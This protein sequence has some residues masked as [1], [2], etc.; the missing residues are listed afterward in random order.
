MIAI[1]LLAKARNERQIRQVERVLNGLFE[2]LEARYEILGTTE[3]KW[4]K[5][6]ITGE[7]ET[8]A[9]KYVIKN[10][11]I[12]PVSITKARKLTGLKGFIETQ[13]C[14]S[15]EM[16]VDIGIFQP[17]V[18]FG[19]IS[20]RSLQIQLVNGMEVELSAVSE[21]FALG[22]NMSVSYKILGIN[23]QDGLIE[24]ELSAAQL[25]RI[26]IW[27]DSLLD[28]LIVT[29][30]SL[31]EV[32]RAL[33]QAMLIRDVIEIETLGILEHALVCKMG[34]DAAGLVPRMGRPLKNAA[35]AVFS[36][37]KIASFL[38]TKSSIQK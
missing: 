25:K 24:G 33:K 4:V 3:T 18:Y 9:S 35:L 1:T 36:P 17:R 32:R 5:I 2:G 27:R 26:R 13:P 11:G 30:A 29:G 38:E 23:E 28:R 16:L 8:V 20:L 12:C 31:V 21:L 7:D 34:T 19:K 15:N 22:R 37:R 10:V 6:E 14:K